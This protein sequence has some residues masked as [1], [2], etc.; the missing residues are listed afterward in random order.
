M[1]SGRGAEAA[2]GGLGVPLEDVCPDASPDANPDARLLSGDAR[3]RGSDWVDSAVWVTTG[4]SAMVNGGG[5]ALWGAPE[6]MGVAGGLRLREMDEP[7]RG[8]EKG[9]AVYS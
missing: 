7:A 3:V 5:V 1:G 2:G 6:R 9:F 4:E 8:E